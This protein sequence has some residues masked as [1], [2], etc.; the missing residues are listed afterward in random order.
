MFNLYTNHVT[1]KA[2]SCMK[3]SAYNYM[4]FGIQYGFKTSYK[5]TMY[6][7][8]KKKI[9]IVLQTTMIQFV[10]WRYLDVVQIQFCRNHDS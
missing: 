6:L 4:I 3:V 1:R 8:I 10:K 5:D 7:V 9:Y 2:R